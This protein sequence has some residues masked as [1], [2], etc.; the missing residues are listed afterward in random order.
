MRLS[1]G[2]PGW[3]PC[4]QAIGDSDLVAQEQAKT[5]ADYSRGDRESLIQLRE[6]PQGIGERERDCRGDQHHP[7]DGSKAK[8]K[9][10]GDCP[11]GMAD[12]RQHE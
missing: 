3:M 6:M 2:Y 12:C 5:Q 9:Q 4:E 1:A 10:V 8:N 7:R 11:S